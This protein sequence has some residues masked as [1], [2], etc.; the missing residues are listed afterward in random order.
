M[1]DHSPLRAIPGAAKKY[2]REIR[3]PRPPTL[4]LETAAQALRYCAVTIEFLQD[5]QEGV[6]RAYSKGY[7][8][9]N[10]TSPE[11]INPEPFTS[12]DRV[13]SI[14][15]FCVMLFECLC[16]AILAS[17]TLAL[18]T[19]AAVAVGVVLTAV[20]TLT[21][22]AVW[23]LHIAPDEV[24]PR[25]ALSTLYR[26]IMPLAAVWLAAL[27]VA[28]LLP[29]IVDESTPA[30][31]LVFNINMSLL[32]VLSP[33]LSGLLFTA[34]NL[35]GWARGRT[36]EYHKL[37]T[38]RRDVEALAEECER[39]VGAS[40]G[41]LPVQKHRGAAETLPR[42]ASGV[43]ALVFVAM[44]TAASAHAQT[45]GEFWLDDSRSPVAQE[46]DSAEDQFFKTLPAVVTQAGASSWEFFRFS[47]NAATARPVTTL[48][49][50]PF[51]SPACDA[52]AE[53]D[54]LTKLFRRPQMAANRASAK[55]CADLRA[56][57][58]DN[59]AREL[60][61]RV[62][63]AKEAF[64]AA[65]RARG[66]CTALMDLMNRLI[67]TPSAQAPRFVVVVSDA[68]ESCVPTREIRLPQPPS[69]MKALMVV[70]PSIEGSRKFTPWQEFELRRQ[71]WRRTAPWLEVISI[72]F[73]NN[74]VFTPVN[75]KAN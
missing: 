62:A 46:L 67:N 70:V 8:A 37:L 23:H 26:W 74:A 11:H 60:S 73:L 4:L 75:E 13:L 52:P 53:R 15:A 69:S 55:Q 30:I 66:T 27:I 28:L 72:P 18:P 34:A 44:F 32:T 68:V 36:R 71:A 64:D 17:M 7:I 22:K 39:A 25:R 10:G 9:W 19:L 33:A 14:G 2:R 56:V 16:A 50:N 59:Y 43:L 57:A 12:F 21:M 65:P 20:F 58:R 24:Q 3:I 6:R 40:G 45:R 41:P 54:E 1:K 48:D 61:A 35:Y 63:R 29:R 51:V 49:M 5:A 38:L 47:R 31:N 42:A